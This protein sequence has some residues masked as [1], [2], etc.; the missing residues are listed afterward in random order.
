MTELPIVKYETAIL[1]KHKGFPQ[2]DRFVYLATLDFIESALVLREIL[3]K[4]KGDVY[5]FAAP[6]QALLQM[7]LLEVKNIY[8]EVEYKNYSPNTS[9]FRWSFTLASPA[10]G[11]PFKTLADLFIMGNTLWKAIEGT[12]QDC[13]EAALIEA[14]KLL[15][16]AAMCRHK[17]T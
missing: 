12:R 13:L 10:N 9:S 6:T 7:W 4:E 14:L 3:D 2:E 17:V 11:I 15:P 1:A 8:V 16:D 5:V